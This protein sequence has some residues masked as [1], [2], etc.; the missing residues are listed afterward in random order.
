[1][2]SAGEGRHVIVKFTEAQEGP[3]SMR[4]RDLLLAEHLALSTLGDAGIAAAKT[5]IYD[6]QAQRFLEVQRF[7]RVGAL[8]RQALI[9]L[10]ALDAE[11]V[12]AANQPWPVI[13]QSLAKQ[14]VITLQAADDVQVL[15]A[16]GALIG[17]T[18]MHYGNLSFVPEQGQPYPL[19][20]AYDVTSMCF[21]PTSSGR[22]PGT[23]HPIILHASV[24]HANWRRAQELAQTYVSKM[25]LSIQFS[26]GFQDCIKALR[27]HLESATLQINRLG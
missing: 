1:V 27:S 13:A 22:L 9:S 2:E 8:G 20:P 15:W 5:S 4:W 19:A 25:A 12:G 18:D 17:N 7:D 11:F 26:A 3:Q 24:S 16:F 6:H 23:I 21:A 10:R 14:G